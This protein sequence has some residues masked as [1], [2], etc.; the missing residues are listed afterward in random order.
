MYT[1]LSLVVVAAT[2]VTMN[3]AMSLRRLLGYAS[4]FDLL[5]AVSLF[6]AFGGS[7]AGL[8]V[9]ASAGLCMALT[10]SLLRCV[11]GYQVLWMHR[12]KRKL[13]PRLYWH[14]VP[15]KGIVQATKDAWA[16]LVWLDRKMHV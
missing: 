12:R 10:L 6:E 14:N 5:F 4:I 8:V 16:S 13:L 3:R 9:A 15:A 11:L 1:G 2:L 7:F